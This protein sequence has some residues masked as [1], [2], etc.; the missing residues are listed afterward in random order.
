MTVVLIILGALLLVGILGY[1][2]WKWVS[3]VC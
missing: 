1:L 2:L 3:R